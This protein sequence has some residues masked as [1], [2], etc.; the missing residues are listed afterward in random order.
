MSGS[1]APENVPLFDF[2]DLRDPDSVLQ[3]ALRRDYIH[4]DLHP[5]V[6]PVKHDPSFL[7]PATA[8]SE[9]GRLVAGLVLADDADPAT[10]LLAL[11]TELLA[12]L[13]EVTP[14]WDA[15]TRVPAGAPRALAL[16]EL[17]RHA[18]ITDQGRTYL[19]PDSLELLGDDGILP[20]LRSLLPLLVGG[21]LAALRARLEHELDDR[22]VHTL[23][24]GTGDYADAFV[25]TRLA[26][27]DCLYL[28]Y[29]LRRWTTV[30]L[31]P[32]M[33]GL[34][35]MH[36]LEGLAVDELL[37]SARAGTAT[38][39]QHAYL[40]AAAPR[41]PA[42]A[43]WTEKAA[44]H[45]PPLIGDVATLAFYL[46]AT[47][48]VH[49]IFA[50]LFHYRRHFNDIKP[51]GVGDLKVVKQ[52]LLA[53]TAGEIA[54]ID[55]VMLGEVKVRSHRRLEK[56]EDVFSMA[57]SSDSE[58]SR[59]TQS[60]A[61]FEV[62]R[63]AEQVIK[64][65]LAGSLNA[66]VTYAGSPV[67]ATA[68]AGFSASHSEARTEKSSHNFAREVVS[69]AVDR[70]VAHTA[71]SRQ[72]TK[73]FETEERNEHTFTNVGGKGHISGI[74]RWVDKRYEAQVYNFGKRMMFE[75]IIPEPAAF[76]VEQ[77]LRAYTDALDLPRRPDVPVME[78]L[79]MDYTPTDINLTKFNELRLKYD[80]T[81]FEYPVTHKTVV[82]AGQDGAGFA[83]TTR[84]VAK[85][86]F[87][88]SYECAVGAAGYSV[89]MIHVTGTVDFTNLGTPAVNDPGD[90]NIAR[91]SIDGTIVWDVDANSNNSWNNAKSVSKPYV[92]TR[93][94]VS[95]TVEVQDAKS[96]VLQFSADVELTSAGLFDWQV[97][98]YNTIRQI[99]Q[100]PVDDRNAAKRLQYEAALSTYRNRMDDV[101]AT[102]IHE[103]IQGASSIAN[104]EVI[105]R[106]LKRG[107]LAML[108]KEFDADGSDDI[109]T[110]KE[111][112]GARGVSVIRHALSI[113]ENQVP[114]VAR[115]KTFTDTKAKVPAVMIEPAKDKARYVQFLEQAFEW[116]QL[117]YVCYPYFWATPPKW[118][119]LMSRSDDADPFLTEFLQAGSAKVLLAACPAYDAAVLHFLATREPWL[120]GDA[121]ALGD[122]LYLP[123]FEEVRRA[124]DDRHGGTAVGE[125]WAFT[126]P[127][128][129]VYLQG[130]Q[131]QLPE[132]P[133]TP[134]P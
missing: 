77:R 73:T 79:G 52:R 103:L 4:D 98:V 19:I 133:Q 14:T 132:L 31:N 6:Q 109:I 90:H 40:A 114:P 76:L 51:I 123:L 100:R 3:P 127:T 28:L 106:E 87:A 128:S 34:R 122:P 74:Y 48:V 42:M 125:P 124:T 97:K 75:F 118:V 61:R 33:N 117:G 22:P 65:D 131:D 12:R 56:T 102:A 29:M 69:K 129:L 46:R 13:I 36:A 58:S 82:F 130:S 68:T 107:C 38:S 57:S 47:P 70:V 54:D 72:I 113:D 39:E 43:H 50:R 112:V 95:V 10:G 55:N 8:G 32:V 120:G 53:Y 37:T 41:F 71:Q 99:E 78:P 101:R 66:T 93:D 7:P 81:A 88:K 108:T 23:V 104:R 86:W 9:I 92:F 44:D 64:T 121:P 20:V 67:T 18:S 60:T 111:T 84:S 59:D 110:N 16:S 91:L 63:E 115:Y 83:E 105:L 2:M 30:D 11:K 85:V 35:G 116:P 17:E 119:E 96:Y 94:D 21:D 1:I 25:S 27:F 49:P 134:V 126:V 26:L 15:R 80:L 5:W 24:F 89:K 62:K 45:D